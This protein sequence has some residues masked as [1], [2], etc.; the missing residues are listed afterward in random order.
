MRVYVTFGRRVFDVVANVLS[1]WRCVFV[2]LC[3]TGSFAVLA[4][5]IRNSDRPTPLY[6]SD[7]TERVNRRSVRAK[8]FTLYD[9]STDVDVEYERDDDRGA[10]AERRIRRL[11]PARRATSSRRR[12]PC[13]ST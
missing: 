12:P 8:S 3:A 9:N 4:T 1:G 5:P 7:G 13:A 6:A 10:S 2:C 11:E